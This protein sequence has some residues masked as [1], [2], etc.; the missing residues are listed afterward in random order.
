MVTGDKHAEGRDRCVN[1]V[2]LSGRVSALPEERELPSGDTLVT[3]RL[4]V[5]RAEKDSRGRRTVD[6]LDCAVRPARLRRSAAAWQP[7][8]VVEVV[9]AIRRR[10]FRTAAGAASRVEIEVRSGRRLRRAASA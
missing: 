3:F 2:R 10:F 8:D 4:V 1:E 9:G 6:V 5:D 7:G